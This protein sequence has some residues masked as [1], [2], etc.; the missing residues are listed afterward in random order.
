[1]LTRKKAVQISNAT[2]CV[3]INEYQ[4]TTLTGEER[5]L[6]NERCDKSNA[7]PLSDS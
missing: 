4:T 3:V 5:A 7:F 2:C 6:I 1:M